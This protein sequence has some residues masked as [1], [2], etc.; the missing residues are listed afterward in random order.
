[1]P[2]ASSKLRVGSLFSGIGGFD[3]GLE[4]AGM[5]VRWQVD[6]EPF[7]QHILNKHW[8]DIPCYSDI[9]DVRGEEVEPVDIL[10]GGFPCQDI[11]NA[12]ARAG[13]TGQRS[14]LWKEYARLVGE[15]RPRY[16]IVENVAA[17]R[18]R[19]LDVVLGDLSLLGYDAEWDRIR[20]S[21][22]GAPHQRARL[23]IVA[24]PQRVE[25]RQQPGR[26]SRSDGQEAPVAP[27]DGQARSLADAD[28]AGRGEQRRAFTA[29][30]QLEA[31]ERGGWWRTEPDVGRV[32]D[33]VPAR[34]DR[35]RGLGNALVPQIAEWIGRQIVAYEEL[36]SV[37]DPVHG[38][39]T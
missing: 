24:Y 29:P 9:R 20:A 28:N 1:M 36:G 11:S 15:L 37:R 34:V 3:L 38:E 25:L 7:A 4:R 31:T 8:P 22:V 21:D 6:N 33:G 23:W 19:G 16:V 18:K 13:I 5:E 27:A 2:K 32:A 26:L 35:L 14:S 30:P 12:G 39:L 17:L 10:C